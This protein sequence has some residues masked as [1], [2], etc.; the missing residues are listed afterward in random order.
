MRGAGRLAFGGFFEDGRTL[1]IA[2]TTDP[3]EA[4]R[5][6]TETDFWKPDALTTRPWLHVL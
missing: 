1:A 3:D 2:K 5:W 4:L 6:F